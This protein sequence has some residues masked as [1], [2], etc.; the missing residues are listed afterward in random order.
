MCIFGHSL[1]DSD[2][3]KKCTSLSRFPVKTDNNSLIL[4]LV[5]GKNWRTGTGRLFL[6]I[7]R[8]RGTRN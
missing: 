7:L 5:I 3:I 8:K 1:V 6:I 2:I 4:M